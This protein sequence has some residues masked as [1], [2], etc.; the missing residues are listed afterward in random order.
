MSRKICLISSTGGHYAQLKEVMS[1]VKK[2]EYFVVTERSKMTEMA[3]ERIYYLRQQERSN[4][5]IFLNLFINF[6][7]SLYILLRERPKI[8]IST[9][10]GAVLPLCIFGRLMGAKLIFI[11]SFAKVSTPTMTGKILYR[12]SN[13]FYVQWEDMEKVYPK[14]LYRGALY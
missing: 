4:I 5:S 3:S 14:A 9:G 8:I 10:A 11:E 7:I 12:I 13:R 6:C 2:F 1:M